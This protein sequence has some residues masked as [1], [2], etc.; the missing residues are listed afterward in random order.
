M[1]SHATTDFTLNSVSC[2]SSGEEMHFQLGQT[3]LD[4]FLPH[5]GLS[6]FKQVIFFSRLT[7]F[8][9]QSFVTRRQL[10]GD[11]DYNMDITDLT[12][13]ITDFHVI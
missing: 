10:V 11:D 6:L 12:F 5:R 3:Q 13:A 9:S 2:G 8:V 4:S 7:N 1:R